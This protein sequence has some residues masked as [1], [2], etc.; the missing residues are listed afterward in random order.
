MGIASMVIGIVAA[1]IGFIPLCGSIAIVPAIIGLILGIVDVA[2]KASKEKKSGEKIPGKGQ[3]IAG[4]VLNACAVFIIVM[5]VY[6]IA[7]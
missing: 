4:I 5:Y 1:V 3:G 6:I 2:L 7:S